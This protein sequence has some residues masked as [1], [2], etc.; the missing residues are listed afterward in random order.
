MYFNA[1]G[2]IWLWLALFVILLF[3]ITEFQER[4]FEWLR[5]KYPWLMDRRTLIIILA[6]C[7]AG[8]IILLMLHP[9]SEVIS[10]LQKVQH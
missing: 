3:V 7:V 4:Y 8:V 2:N 5:R 9:P 1:D 6:G 10:E